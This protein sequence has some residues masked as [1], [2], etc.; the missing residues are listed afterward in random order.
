MERINEINFVTIPVH[1][2]E[3]PSLEKQTKLFE[4]LGHTDW[5]N[6]RVAR[7]QTV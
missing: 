4:I 1:R 7:R 5:R 3:S 2:G 6:N